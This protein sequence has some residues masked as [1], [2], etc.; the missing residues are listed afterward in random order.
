MQHSKNLKN[1]LC[2]KL[3]TIVLL[4]S[5]FCY[6]LF[7]YK[8][9]DYESKYQEGN[10]MITGK[11]IEKKETDK[12][13]VLVINAKEKI[14]ATYYKKEKDFVKFKLGDKIL[15]SGILKKPTS[16]TNFNLFNY[17]NYLKSKNIYSVITIEKYK[18]LKENNNIFYKIKN[19]LI[20]YFENFKSRNYLMAF[21][22]GDTSYIQ[23]EVKTSYQNNGISHLFAVSGMH[24]TLFV[25]ILSLIL[26]KSIKNKKIIFLFLCCFLFFYAFLANFSS[27][28]LRGCG[29]Y[30]LN[31]LRKYRKWPCHSLQIFIFLFCI[32]LIINPYILYH[33]GFLFSFSVSFSLIFF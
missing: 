5:T 33:S 10:I 18:I 9:N 31:E 11:I 30:I 21:L 3:F 17:E 1:L 15:V 8:T 25:H 32:F 2:S 6:L 16:N 22:L 24:I 14:Q 23:D 20:D 7:Y 19:D 12:K 27:S 4:L 28:I 29:C 26:N 13:I